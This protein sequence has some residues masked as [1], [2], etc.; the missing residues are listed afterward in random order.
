M[1]WE[2]FERAATRYEQW[3]E[4]ELGHRA[5]IAERRLLKELL[6]KLPPSRTVLEVGSGTGHFCR[7]LAELGFQVVG[8]ERSPLMAA[9]ARRQLASIP[10]LIGDA[11]AL[12]L[13]SNTVD[14]VMF[15]TTLE[16]LDNARVA[17]SEAVRVAR[18]GVVALVLNRWSLGG[19]SRRIGPQSR[20]SL[21]AHAHDYSISELRRSLIKAA[22]KRLTTLV[23]SSTLFPNGLAMRK[24]RFPFFGDV[25]GA[26]ISLQSGSN[27][28]APNGF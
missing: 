19:L 3:Y 26:A 13:R 2:I 4:T 9:E 17:L 22:G 24:L 27:V 8:L 15:V 25:V 16:F 6:E 14:V 5:D 12:P 28:I 20:G 1:T 11:G 21:L 18:R 7:W 23:W 10:L